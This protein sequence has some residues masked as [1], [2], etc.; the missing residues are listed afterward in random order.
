VERQMVVDVDDIYGL[1][2]SPQ[3]TATMS[4]QELTKG[5]GKKLSPY[6]LLEFFHDQKVKG[7]AQPATIFG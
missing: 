7:I 5:F 2:H 3:W 1:F 6:C 4:L